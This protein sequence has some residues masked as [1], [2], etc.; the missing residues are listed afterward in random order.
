MEFEQWWFQNKNLLCSIGPMFGFHDSIFGFH[1][2]M[3]GFHDSIFG[4]HDSM[5]GFHDSMFSSKRKLVGPIV[6][7]MLL[8]QPSIFLCSFVPHLFSRLFSLEW[9]LFDFRGGPGSMQNDQ[10]PTYISCP[11]ESKTHVFFSPVSDHQKPVMQKR[12]DRNTAGHG[13][14]FLPNVRPSLW[15]PVGCRGHVWNC[16]RVSKRIQ[17]GIWLRWAICEFHAWDFLCNMKKILRLLFLWHRCLLKG[18]IKKSQEQDSF[19]FRPTQ[20]VC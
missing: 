8:L 15:I 1:D 20:Q 19:D 10:V 12:L 9:I 2:S 11:L 13:R 3:F 14:P 17:S 5:F 7:S 18:L 6:Y 16:S 4:F